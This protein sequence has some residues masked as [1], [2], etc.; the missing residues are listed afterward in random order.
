M[1]AIAVSSPTGESR[2][3]TSVDQPNSD[4]WSF[5]EIPSPAHSRSVANAVVDRD[6]GSERGQE[7]RPLRQVRRGHVE[8]G[9]HEDGPDRVPRVAHRREHAARVA[10]ADQV[11]RRAAEHHPGGHEQR[12]GAERHQEEHGHEHDLGRHREAVA[13]GEANP[14]EERVGG[15]QRE[16]ERQVEGA[17]RRHEDGHRHGRGDERGR[18]DRFGYSFPATKG[19]GVLP[20]PA[21]SELFDGGR[22]TGA[23]VVECPHG[24]CV[25]RQIRGRA[26]WTSVRWTDV[27]PANGRMSV[28]RNGEDADH[29]PM[30][31]RLRTS[32]IAA[33]VAAAALAVGAPSA[34]AGL[35][36]A[37]APDCSAE[38]DLGGL[39]EGRRRQHPVLARAGRRLRG[40]QQVVVAQWRRVTGLGQRALE[41]GGLER[42]SLA[43]AP[44]GRFG[45]VTGGVRGHR[46]SGGAVVREEQQGLLSTLAVD[47]ITETSLGL[48]VAVPA[49]VLL[50]NGQWKPSPKLVVLSSLLPLFPGE[51]TPVQFR[52]TSVGLGTWS[53]DD[54]Y[55]D[56]RCH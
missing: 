45:H 23:E 25:Y 33:S 9:Q 53:V 48:K 31:I 47:V 49:G 3:S 41:A 35:L 43:P 55:I 50:P 29:C 4:G 26:L 34:S 21:L 30:R 20:V 46:A 38:A 16:R 51:H 22:E 6:L 10:V 15:H 56:P 5:G 18:T 17:V 52:V 54:F 7:D 11:L 8:R 19:L 36:V 44:A 2:M 13:D 24:S 14:R 28:A 32:I 12:N 40:R 1:A 39:L 37:S 27:T 42:R